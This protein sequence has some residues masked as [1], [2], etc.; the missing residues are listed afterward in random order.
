MTSTVNRSESCSTTVRQ[1]PLTA[2]EA[3]CD[4]IGGDQWSGHGQPGRVGAGLERDDVAELLDDSGEHQRSPFSEAVI[5]TSSPI[6]VMSVGCRRSAWSIEVMPRSL[7]DGRPRPSRTGRDVGDELVDEV[8]RHE[9]RRDGGA[10]LEPDVVDL[11]IGERRQDVLGIAGPQ[12]PRGRRVVEDA[13]AGWQVALT[14]HH[15]D[16]LLGVERAVG[17]ARGQLRVVEQGGAGAHEDRPAP[18]PL[19]VDV[20]PGR[21]A[22]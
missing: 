12:L 19:L 18:R 9:G 6:R 3:P 14:H 2:I 4:G 17:A 13:G 10:A 22:R 21:F 7:T 1:T 16:R 11:G 15:A 8:G 20:G 5:R